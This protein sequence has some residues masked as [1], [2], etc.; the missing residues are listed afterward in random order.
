V[1]RILRLYRERFADWNVRHFYRFARRDHGAGKSLG[2][3][4]RYDL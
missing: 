2:S 4:E 1:Q 3:Y